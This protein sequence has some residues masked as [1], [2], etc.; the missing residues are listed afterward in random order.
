M[1]LGEWEKAGL[2]MKPAVSGQSVLEDDGH[3]VIATDRRWLAS[4]L[5]TLISA[6]RYAFFDIA[7]AG[8]P[9]VPQVRQIESTVD[10]QVA[11]IVSG[12]LG[13]R[14]SQIGLKAA[15]SALPS[16]WSHASDGARPP[17]NQQDGLHYSD[18]SKGMHGC[19]ERRQ[20]W[21]EQRHRQT[22]YARRLEEV[23]RIGGW[24]AEL[25]TAVATKKLSI[26]Q[27]EF[28]VSDEEG[29][30]ISTVLGS[31]VAACIFDPVSRVGAMNHFLLPG[32]P[33][34]SG[35]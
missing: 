1:S 3:G 34:R 25:N 31:C 35:S 8:E 12:M 20:T 23:D 5:D 22:V 14:N 9:Q 27:G 24:E 21:R 32:N 15:T 28:A 33:D 11:A 6:N 16:A 30:Y 10:W 18:R 29:A 13:D 7:G 17:E 26:I 19:P 4:R 2:E